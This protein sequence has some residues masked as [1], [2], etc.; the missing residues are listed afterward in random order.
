M[1]DIVE[2]NL[3]Y[4]T[5]ITQLSTIVAQWRPMAT[6]GSLLPDSTKLLPAPILT[7]RQ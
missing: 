3:H 6:T 4:D 1:V 5:F 7:Y 2:D